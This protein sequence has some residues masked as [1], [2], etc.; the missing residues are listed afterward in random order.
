[1]SDKIMV[2]F[3][4]GGVL[5]FVFMMLRRKIR[6]RREREKIERERNKEF[7][8]RFLYNELPKSASLIDIV[9]YTGLNMFKVKDALSALVKN[10]RV[11]DD[12]DGIY[13]TYIALGDNRYKYGN[14]R[15]VK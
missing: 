11:K 10:G 7:I 6:L 13:F 12:V 5:G 3:L 14:L 1:M 9:D 4:I 2:I 15:L 8:A